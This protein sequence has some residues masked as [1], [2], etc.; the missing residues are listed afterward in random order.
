MVLGRI[1]PGGLVVGLA[2]AGVLGACGGPAQDDGA[3]S[4]TTTTA[5]ADKSSGEDDSMRQT[6]KS[7][8]A[9][10]SPTTADLVLDPDTSLEVV[11]LGVDSTWQV[12]DILHRGVPHE[13]E[14]FVALSNGGEAKIL[15]NR[16][17]NFDVVLGNADVTSA[18]EAVSVA[19]V[20][21]DSTRSL[22]TLT[23]RVASADD[24][25]WR[26]KLDEAG[27]KRR[28]EVLAKGGRQV[29]APIATRSGDSW[30]VTAWT[31]TGTNLVRHD[32]TIGDASVADRTTVVEPKLPVVI[33]V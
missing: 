12:V 26:P 20:F 33:G 13:R 10:V 7:A 14:V 30:Q 2:V 22:S 18:E 31:V 16:P 21:L 27:E 8:L 19:K 3:G 28:A 9:N 25:K 32:I 5:T 6:L 23:Y 1:R 11:R 24:I 29:A 17:E 4:T 15:T